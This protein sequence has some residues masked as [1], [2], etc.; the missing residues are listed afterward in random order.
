MSLLDRHVG[1]VTALRE[2]GLTVSVAEG[3]DAVESMRSVDLLDRE[4]LRTALAA[5]LVKRHQ[6]RPAFDAV[7][8][9]FYPPVT[10]E[11]A[12]APS[13]TI[14]PERDTGAAPRGPLE[15][16]VRDRIRADVA[17]FRFSGTR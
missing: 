8:D 11:S 4:E 3:I 6:H 14:P 13:D 15:D 5:T 10:G 16:P 9:V 2:A 17:E 12:V 1:F 7:F